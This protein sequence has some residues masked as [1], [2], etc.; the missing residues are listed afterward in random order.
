MTCNRG[1]NGSHG[2]KWI[3]PERRLAIYHRDGF[4]CV[5][6]KRAADDARLSLDHLRSRKRGG[7]N[8]NEN[9]VTACLRCNSRRREG[10]L[11]WAKE[12]GLTP[13]AW[14]RIIGRARRPVDLERG[15]AI[16]EARR[17]AD[18]SVEAFSKTFGFVD[19]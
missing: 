16:L 13:A 4:A 12:I 7:T 5:Y 2:S 11:A 6:C 14:A 18:R 3:R 9:L 19:A 10:G 8:A 17:R 15:R 1:S